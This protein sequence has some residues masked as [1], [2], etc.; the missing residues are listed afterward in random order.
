MKLSTRHNRHPADYPRVTVGPENP[1]RVERDET[2][3]L[4]C[5]VDSKPSVQE[6]RW[7]RDGRFV[8]T[9][10]RS[11]ARLQSFFRFHVLTA[12]NPGT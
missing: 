1:I 10:F 7:V 2:A 4:Y 11:V 6:V 12:L 9:Q 3:E 5:D 8:Q